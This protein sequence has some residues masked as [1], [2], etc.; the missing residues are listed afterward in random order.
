MR[1]SGCAYNVPACVHLQH[2]TL[3]RACLT[4]GQH[5]R[6]CDTM[7]VSGCAYHLPHVCTYD[8]MRVSVSAYHVPAF[9]HL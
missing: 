4:F 9:V 5:A 7:R 8:T 3:E 2:D 6:T 1:V